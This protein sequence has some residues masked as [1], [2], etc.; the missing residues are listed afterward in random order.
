MKTTTIVSDITHDDIVNLLSTALYGSTYMSADYDEERYK[1]LFK[2]SDCYE[3]KMARILLDGGSITIT[4][5]YA[6][7]ADEL[8]G[9]KGKWNE[10]LDEAQYVINLNDIKEGLQMAM[11]GT[12]KVNE[13]SEDSERR[14]A[15]K[16]VTNMMA[17]DGDYDLPD[18]DMI[19]Q[20]ICFGGLVYG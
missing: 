20:I 17:E 2:E 9:K 18:A 10:D 15:K 1:R 3:D 13:G 5:S 11:D 6:E 16:V 7:S 14:W 8:N 19:M 4:D 12:F